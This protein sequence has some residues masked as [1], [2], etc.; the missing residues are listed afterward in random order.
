MAS[1]SFNS[2][3]RR[4]AMGVAGP[5]R[6]GGLGGGDGLV[7]LAEVSARAGGEEL[8]GG[9]VDDV[10]SRR[11]GDEASVDQQVELGSRVGLQ[12]GIHEPSP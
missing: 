11:A 8:F 6:K 7:Q 12:L 3:R 5:S 9:G 10:E 2:R 4:S 1:A